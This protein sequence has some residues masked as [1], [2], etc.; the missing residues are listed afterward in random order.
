MKWHCSSEVSDTLLAELVDGHGGH[1]AVEDLDAP[2]CEE[3]GN[4]EP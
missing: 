4:L 3:G 1:E 2:L